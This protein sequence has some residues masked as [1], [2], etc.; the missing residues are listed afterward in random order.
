MTKAQLH[1]ALD[2]VNATRE[3][4]TE[5]A[6][7]VCENPDLVL[8]LLEICFEFDNP[9]SAK[10]CWVMEFTVKE[11]LAYLFPHLDFFTENIGKAHLDSAVRPLAKV[12]ELLMK[13]FFN[14][15][16]IE[17][18]SILT[19]EHLKKITTACFDWLIGEHKVA[20]KAYSMA[21]L[22]LLGKKYEWIHTE[23]KMVLEQNYND[24]SAAY[25]ARARMVLGKLK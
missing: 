5:M 7:M 18:K 11:S 23:L 24:G 14:R 6:N 9:I 25:K 19:E 13:S 21:S 17:T 8:P 15:T 12:C 4:R 20:T 1:E 16:S 10:A 22:F 3:K 2:Y